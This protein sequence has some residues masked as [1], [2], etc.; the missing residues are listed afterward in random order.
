MNQINPQIF[1]EYDIRGVVG[2]DLNERII[3]RIGKAYGTYMRKLGK[4]KVSLGR[5]CRLSSP[6]FAKAISNGITST[7]INVID[8][9]M[10]TTPMVYVSLFNLDVE[11]GVMITA[12][13]N[14]SEYN[15]VK[16]C[17]GKETLFAGS[18]TQTHREH[19]G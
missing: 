2:E 3:E 13:H 10:V 4:K 6:A 9:G 1:R 17:V 7:G 18:H 11:G 5:D 8:I 15:G 14:P 16:L 19:A 12:S